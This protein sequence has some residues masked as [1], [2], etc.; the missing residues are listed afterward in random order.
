MAEAKI[1]QIICKGGRHTK[2]VH[3]RNTLV[4]EGGLNIVTCGIGADKVQCSKA[5]KALTAEVI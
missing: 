1:G 2:C 4:S 5:G 3:K